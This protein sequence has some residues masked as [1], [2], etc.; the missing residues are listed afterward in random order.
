MG[1]RVT[2]AQTGPTGAPDGS[3]LTPPSGAPEE[4]A[5]TY[6][7]DGTLWRPVRSTDIA[8]GTSSNAGLV[9]GLGLLR[10]GSGVVD[11]LRGAQ[12]SAALISRGVLPVCLATPDGGNFNLATVPG[13]A[14]ALLTAQSV[15]AHVNNGSTL[16]VLRGN[17][18]VTLLASAARTAA[19]QSPDQTNFNGRGVHV[20]VNM[21]VF[22]GA[23]SITPTIQGKDPI[24]GTYY[25]ILAGPAIS[26]NGLTV[27]KVYP[28][29]TTLATAV[30]NDILVRTWR[31]SVAVADATSHTYSVASVV[32]L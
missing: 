16:D 29:L 25:T 17:I 18:E 1:V 3:G 12:A 6:S 22:G 13:D 4:I 5:L 20:L 7:F 10:Q 23:G 32:I 28:G 8:D 21:S 31:V 19:T 27:L 11:L 30:A 9:V 2:P 24:S 15:A 14:K 26:A